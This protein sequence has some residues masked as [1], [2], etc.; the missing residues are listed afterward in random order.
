MVEQVVLSEEAGNEP[1]TNTLSLYHVRAICADTVCPRVSTSLSEG[2]LSAREARG[3]LPAHVT[4]GEPC[5]HLPPQPRASPVVLIF[6]GRVLAKAV[7]GLG[8]TGFITLSPCGARGAGSGGTRDSAF[9]GPQGGVS[10]F[11]RFTLYWGI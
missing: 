6:I 5:G 2:M 7:R 10:E 1:N 9:L 8:G 3:A 11:G 4:C